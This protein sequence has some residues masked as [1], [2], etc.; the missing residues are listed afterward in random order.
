MLQQI[1]GDLGGFEYAFIQLNLT[2]YD[3]RDLSSHEG[4]A[5]RYNGASRAH[6]LLND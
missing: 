1:R 2:N 5:P 6:N 3:G 4:T